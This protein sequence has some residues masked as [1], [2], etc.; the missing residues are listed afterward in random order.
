M[1]DC[2]KSFA[3]FFFVVAVFVLA[4]NLSRKLLTTTTKRMSLPSPSPLSPTP[5]N[6]DSGSGHFRGFNH[7]GQTLDPLVY[8]PL[9]PCLANYI[10]SH[11][12]LIII[13]II[14]TDNSIISNLNVYMFDN[15]S[16]LAAMDL[17]LVFS[18]V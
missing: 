1:L 3:V 17:V 11:P 12:T 5:P 9:C 16:W 4:N 6:L 18:K 2:T 14:K 10:A 8:C 15:Q 7:H 13:I